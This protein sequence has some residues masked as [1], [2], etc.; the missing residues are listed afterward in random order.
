MLP[1]EE[2]ILRDVIDYIPNL[3]SSSISVSRVP[4]KRELKN[5]TSIQCD[6]LLQVRCF[7]CKKKSNNNNDLT[8]RRAPGNSSRCTD[9]LIE[10]HFFCNDCL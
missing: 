5:V 2:K 3:P 4:L 8:L 7:K 6:K 1:Y 9:E 10:T